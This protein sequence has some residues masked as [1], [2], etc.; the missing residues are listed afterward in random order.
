[1]T[2]AIKTLKDKEL[3]VQSGR[4]NTQV[5]LDLIKQG[6]SINCRDSTTGKTPLHNAVTTGNTELFGVLLPA[7]AN[8]DVLDFNRCTALYFAAVFGRCKMIE[9]LAS[10]G[11]SVTVQNADGYTPL[12]AAAMLQGRDDAAFLLL[13]LGA[14]VDLKSEEGETPLLVAMRKGRTNICLHLLERGVDLTLAEFD[15]A[16]EVCQTKHPESAAAIAAWMALKRS[17][18]ALAEAGNRGQSPSKIM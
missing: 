12:H 7:V 15:I 11:A 8:V 14:R 1:M 13:S 3:L 5:C 9:Q 2:I 18:E 17:R 16:R 6:A 4:F 10:Y